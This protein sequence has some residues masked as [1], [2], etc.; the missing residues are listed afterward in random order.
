MKFNQRG[1]IRRY[2]FS[3]C[4]AAHQRTKN[5]WQKNYYR[6]VIGWDANLAENNTGAMT[7]ERKEYQS[8]RESINILCYCA[9]RIAARKYTFIHHTDNLTIYN[10]AIAKWRDGEIDYFIC[11]IIRSPYDGDYSWNIYIKMTFFVMMKGIDACFLYFPRSFER[12]IP[13]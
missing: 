2:S 9:R 8:E 12:R 3:I 5:K 1:S 6:S 10:L 7:H 11:G 4:S 13:H